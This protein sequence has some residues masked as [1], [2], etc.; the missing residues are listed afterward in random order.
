MHMLGSGKALQAS[1]IDFSLLDL[2]PISPVVDRHKQLMNTRSCF[3]DPSTLMALVVLCGFAAAWYIGNI[4]GS[5][6][7]VT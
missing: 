6:M 2:S 1:S 4:S 5:M 7:R 3:A